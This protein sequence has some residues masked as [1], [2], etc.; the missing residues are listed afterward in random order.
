MIARFSLL[1]G[2]LFAV[3]ASH[4][5]TP[6]SG[7]WGDRNNTRTGMTFDVQ[8]NILLITAYTYG[9]DGTPGWFTSAGVL[10]YQFNGP[11]Q[12]PSVRYTGQFDRVTGGTCIGCPTPTSVGVAPGAGGSFQID[13]LSAET[14]VMTYLG[15]VFPIDRSTIGF[16]NRN[17]LL[18]GEWALTIDFG[19]RGNTAVY[20]YATWPYFGEVFLIDRYSTVF[21]VEGCRPSSLTIGACTAAQRT[22]RLLL[23]D[24]NAQNG[25]T[26][27]VMLD[28]V[29]TPLSQYF[30]YFLTV[31]PSEMRGVVEIVTN[32][33][34]TGSGPFYPVRGARTRSRS[35]VLTGSGPF[36]IDPGTVDAVHQSP[37]HPDLAAALIQNDSGLSREEAIDALGMSGQQFDSMA[38]GVRAKLERVLSSATE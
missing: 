14:A 15:R 12:Q 27:F 18:F 8:N 17:D 9:P 36:S 25:V 20:P 10:Q 30:V 32:P 3:S 22:N 31:T 26:A 2:L 13:F 11:G 34:Q 28:A 4:A 19:A 37:L 29:G 24:Y 21:A 1:I 7:L 35:F 6:E 23:G 33:N 16:G 5:F 38:Y